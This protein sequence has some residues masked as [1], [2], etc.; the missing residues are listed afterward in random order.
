MTSNLPMTPLHPSEPSPSR[1]ETEWA[2]QLAP[3]MAGQTSDYHG[4]Q[5][6]YEITAAEY[7][8]I[9][10][11]RA[12]QQLEGKPEFTPLGS[13][14]RPTDLAGRIESPLRTGH[15][16]V[17][18]GTEYTSLPSYTFSPMPGMS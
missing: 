1:N 14:H 5:R 16:Q 6:A 17:E 8:L 10:M 15:P 11:H 7:D 13:V 4:V 3:D 18:T 2:S 9:M 12:Q